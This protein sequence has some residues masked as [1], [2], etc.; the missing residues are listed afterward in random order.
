[1]I[2]VEEMRFP[3]IKWNKD[4]LKAQITEFREGYADAIIQNDEDYK[5]AKKDRAEINA[6]LKKISDQRIQ[7]KKAVMKPYEVFEK[8]LKNAQS[9]LEDIQKKIASTIK[10]YEDEQSEKKLNWIKDVFSRAIEGKD[11]DFLTLERIF[12]KKWM[13]K[14][15][16]EEDVEKAITARVETIRNNLLWI[17]E[18]EDSTIR[19]TARKQYEETLEF[20]AIVRLVADIKRRREEEEKKAQEERDESRQ[21]DLEALRNRLNSP[22]ETTSTPPSV[23]VPD[24]DENA[25][26]S[27]IQRYFSAFCVRGTAEQIMRLR[28]SAAE[29]GLSVTPLRSMDTEYG[30]VYVEGTNG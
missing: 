6:V 28:E 3:N 7:V 4:E 8:E 15:T 14:S 26:E 13:N 25:S 2:I 22:N 12:D 16:K 9:D 21:N 18:V 29:I 30:R 27:E 5:A 10:E 1:M 24:S 17:A 19:A 20:G 11:M 23:S